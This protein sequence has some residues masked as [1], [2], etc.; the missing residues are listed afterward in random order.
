MDD[1]QGLLHKREPLI[2]RL[3]DR[4]RDPVGSALDG[5][6]SSAVILARALEVRRA[7]MP[8][9]LIANIAAFVP[10]RRGRKTRTFG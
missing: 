7:R 1:R 5:L 9:A 6:I 3:H 4:R 2:V 8:V 10:E